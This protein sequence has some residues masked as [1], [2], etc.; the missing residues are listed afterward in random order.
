MADTTTTVYRL[1][2]EGFAPFDATM[3]AVQKNIDSVIVVTEKL[4]RTS[5]KAWKTF[6]D[7]ANT[8][9]VSIV[10]SITAVT[11]VLTTVT[12][13]V[14]K[15]GSDFQEQMAAT[16][17]IT[18]T[19]GETLEQFGQHAR[20]IGRT[21]PLELSK[22]AIAGG[23]LVRAGLS[24]QESMGGATKAVSNLTVAASG[25]LGLENA[26]RMVA[27]GLLAFNL[28]A[29]DAERVAN[30]LTTAA[31]KS[32]I[33][34]S[35]VDRSFRQAASVAGILGYTVE[36]TSAAIGILGLSFL[37]GSDAGT[38]LKQM[39]ISL[40]KPSK[41]AFRLMQEYGLSLYDAN[42][43]VLPFKQV[44]QQLNKA[45]GEE[46][47]TLNGIS[48]AQ[49]DYALATIFGS[50]AIRA[51]IILS[52]RG[53][54][55][56]DDMMDSM[57]DIK[58]S[59]VA[60][61]MTKEVL[62]K[63]LLLTRNNIQALAIE[64]SSG[65][66]PSLAKMVTGFN[67]L[68]RAIKPEQVKLFGRA[69]ATVMESGDFGKLGEDAAK[70]LGPDAL[71]V[72]RA[73][74]DLMIK[75]NDVVMNKVIPSF[76][77]LAVSISK[78]FGSGSDILESGLRGLSNFLVNVGRAVMVVNLVLSNLITELGKSS[79]AVELFKLTL[80]GITILPFIALSMVALKLGV[81]LFGLVAP[82]ALVSILIALLVNNAEKIAQV[83]SGAVVAAFALMTEYADDAAMAVGLLGIAI[84][85]YAAVVFARALPAA[86]AVAASYAEQAR[87]AAFVF[88]WQVRL[89]QMQIVTAVS[90]FNLARAISTVSATML[91][92]QKTVA[93]FIARM[94]FMIP[95]MTLII[96]RFVAMRTAALANAAAMMVVNFVYALL[97]RSILTNIKAALMW[98]AAM[99]GAAVRVALSFMATLIPAVLA[100][101]SVITSM[102]APILIVIGIIGA[103]WAATQIF[104][105]NWQQIWEDAKAIAAQILTYI[106]DRIEDFFD[107]LGKLPIVGEHIRK[108]G[109]YITQ[110][111]NT[112]G[113]ALGT[114]GKAVENFVSDAQKGFPELQ[115]SLMGVVP[116]M[117]DLD[118]MIKKYEEDAKK[119]G[120]TTNDFDELLRK[121]QES[122]G[123]EPG[124]FE[125]PETGDAEDDAKAIFEA[126]RRVLS[127]IPG[128]TK[129]ALEYFT[130]LTKD[131]PERFNQITAAILGARSEIEKM[132]VAQ[133][134]SLDL[135]K[136]IADVEERI[137][138]IQQAIRVNELKQQAVQLQYA[139]QLLNIRYKQL[140]LDMQ[141]AYARF[142]QADVER[143]I[144]IL[145]RENLDYARQRTQ[146]EIESLPYRHQIEDIEREI[147]KLVDKRLTLELREQELLQEQAK[148]KLDAQLRK[149][150]VDLDLAWQS[151]DVSEILRL[152]EMKATLE[153]QNKAIEENIDLIND[154]QKEQSIAEELAKIGLEK[155]KLALEELLEPYTEQIRKIN[156]LTEVEKLQNQLAIYNLES[157][158]RAIEDMIWP[159]E[160]QKASLDLVTQSIELQMASQTL[161]LELEKIQLEKQ[162]NAE[163]QRREQL[164]STKKEHDAAFAKMVLNFVNLMFQSGAFTRD[165]AVEVV[166][167]LGFWNDQIAA[168]V[169]TTIKMDAVTEAANNIGKA[170]DAIPTTKVVDI[171]INEHYNKAPTYDQ[172]NPYDAGGGAKGYDKGGIVPGSYN[173]PQIATV[174]GGEIW[175][176]TE[177]SI[178]ANVANAAYKRLAQAGMGASPT[179][180]TN[181]YNVNATYERQQDP[182][183]IAMDLRAI[184]G[185][186]Q[187]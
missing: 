128:M 43:E 53:T 23:E 109:A 129:E 58:V 144:S 92:A 117:E 68:L 85:G 48:E 100:A 138:T 181:N 164:L 89:R 172:Y 161:Q 175:L 74:V 127:Q 30:A 130:D 159:L 177:R 102:A 185:S 125:P 76:R 63:Q 160:R 147:A 41:E 10:S 179:M 103:L 187:R 36:D 99:V 32:A 90:S 120:E 7:A 69:I 132:V 87:R 113:D 8:A 60:A 78:V 156:Q 158:K 19:T 157:Q 67:T 12:G 25:E 54:D 29:S 81:A 133:Q 124:W 98:A 162:I 135:A 140:E 1:V 123:G 96:L 122:M 154:K 5:D 62:N 56:Y 171:Y 75:V 165:E 153:D 182:I 126:Y 50:D 180:I 9:T 94:A 72:F 149:V 178:P 79:I 49:R 27:G 108:I 134:R 51:A 34:F 40:M 106:A 116:G 42:Q 26:A 139:S 151:Q 112:A 21:I 13:A 105:I 65:L 59:E 84:A 55:A 4:G 137:E 131:A 107:M 22:I 115:K 110:F 73:W 143:Q 57:K 83:V 155:E 35:D 71:K 66:V 11:A 176:G 2:T 86:L 111:K 148:T 6:S 114:A 28:K 142:Q 18:A 20:D 93:L 38:A 136:Q 166:K 88:V 173:Q 46:A 150:Q 170:I 118:A 70:S 174:H 101:I 15:M 167:R 97:Y 104:G 168:L 77:V 37:R 14:V 64:A 186:A 24:V 141:I 44:I 145:Q 17:A 3:K 152:E 163:E 80:Q 31:V 183:T 169:E 52:N 61:A 47:R 45:F 95:M 119:A 33:T 16:G 184:V 82:I 39:F 91:L 121:L 146:L